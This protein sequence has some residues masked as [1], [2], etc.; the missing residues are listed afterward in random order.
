MKKKSL[1]V[2]TERQI[3]LKDVTAQVVQIVRES[4]VKDGLCVVF[5]PHTT[6][7]LAIN[8]N[9]DPDV[10][11]DLEHAFE[12]MV[13][14]IHFRHAEGNS[15]GHLLSCVSN[16]SLQIL[17]EEGELQLGRW[18]GIYFCEFDG[19]RHRQLWIKVIEA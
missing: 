1:S 8:E 17:V 5:N 15:P 14:A 7:G 3:Q 2:R 16:H 13:P 10:A 6:A 11:T 12:A 9:A 4:G 19:P 18:Q